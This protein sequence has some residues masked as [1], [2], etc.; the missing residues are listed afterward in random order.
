MKDEARKVIDQARSAVD[1]EGIEVE[2]VV[3]QG[4]PAERINEAAETLGVDTIIM[5]SRGVSDMRGMVFGS[6]SHKVSH[7]AG[8]TVVTVT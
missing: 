5:G 2:E 6:V 4:R 3:R 8:C 7:T 1:L